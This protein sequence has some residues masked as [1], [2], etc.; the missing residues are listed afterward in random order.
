M[1]QPCSDSASGASGN[2]GQAWDASNIGIAASRSD[3]VRKVV[4]IVEADSRLTALCSDGSIWVTY[5]G[6]D[7]H[8]LTPPPGCG[9]GA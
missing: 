1:M 4:Q 8:E 7:W 9:G 3:A 2:Q 5:N 6:H